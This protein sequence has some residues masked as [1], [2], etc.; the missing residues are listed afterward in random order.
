MT[1]PYQIYLPY[2]QRI[3]TPNFLPTHLRKG[4]VSGVGGRLQPCLSGH[5][6]GKLETLPITG[7]NTHEKPEIE[8]FIPSNSNF[9]VQVF[10][11]GLANDLDIYKNMKKSQNIIITL[12]NLI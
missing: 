11:W 6:I 8:G 2:F 10:P 12:S 1:Y 9:T 7:R 5:K 3:L 4:F